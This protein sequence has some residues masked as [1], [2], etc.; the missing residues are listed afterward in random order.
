MYQYWKCPDFRKL[1]LKLETFRT[2]LGETFEPGQLPAVM[3][4]D[5][6]SLLQEGG[7]M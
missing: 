6:A 1:Q 3:N 2:I 4:A 7:F 5:T